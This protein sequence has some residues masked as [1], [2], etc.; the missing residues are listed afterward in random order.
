MHLDVLIYTLLVRKEYMVVLL[1][2]GWGWLKMAPCTQGIGVP[3]RET[4]QRSTK[5]YKLHPLANLFAKFT[6]YISSASLY[7]VRGNHVQKFRFRSSL[8][9]LSF[10]LLFFLLP[11]INFTQKLQRV[12]DYSKDLTTVLLFVIGLGRCTSY[13]LRATA[14]KLQVTQA[15]RTAIKSGVA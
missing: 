7:Q 1:N 5:A 14:T 3:P 13:D 6:V 9:F 10:F 4:K 11:V 8:F 12:C 2:Q 15:R